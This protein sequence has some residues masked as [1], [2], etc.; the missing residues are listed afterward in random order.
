MANT[1]DKPIYEAIGYTFFENAP[2]VITGLILSD[3]KNNYQFRA[4]L[5]EALALKS[6]GR[7][8]FPDT[9]DDNNE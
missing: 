4:S 5:L 9:D 6:E 1:S 8:K 7:I 3:T 2:K